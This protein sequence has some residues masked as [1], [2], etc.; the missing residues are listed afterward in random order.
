MST[1]ERQQ[2]AVVTDAAS[3]RPRVLP[4]TTF[5]FHLLR[6]RLPRD[7][8][9]LELGGFIVLILA[10]DVVRAG[11]GNGVVHAAFAHARDIVNSEG[12]VFGHL[13]IPLNSW[14]LTQ[15]AL[16]V[17]ACYVYALAHYVMTPGVLVLSRRRGGWQ[18]WRGYL[19]LVI[20]SGIALFFYATFP[21]APPRLLPHLGIADVLR[22]YSDYGWWGAAASAPR[23]IGDATNQY[24][25]MPSMHCGW[26][27][28]CGI[29]MW[30]FRSKPWRVAAVAYPLVVSY[31]VIATGNH[32]VLDVL[33][34]MLCVVSAYAILKLARRIWLSTTVLPSSALSANPDGSPRH[35]GVGAP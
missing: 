16:A 29:Q 14:L 18:Y 24:A 31:V 26:A 7:R 17:A 11:G 33:A 4:L 6:D 3:L 2:S 12:W 22:S 32:Y 13:E 25:A 27:L 5:A 23:G 8:R 1:A 30:G 19:A 28:W 20:A 21:V 15:P 34:G 9:V 35:E 10:Y